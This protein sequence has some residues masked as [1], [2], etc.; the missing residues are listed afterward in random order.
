MRHLTRIFLLACTLA[1]AA[2]QLAA[3]PAADK[4]EEK[5]DT[6]A[7]VKKTPYEKLLGA[8]T[9]TV[10]GM[11]TVHIKKGKT[12]FEIPDSLYGREIVMGATVKSISDNGA[13]LVGSKNDLQLISFAREGGKVQV[14]ERNVE[15]VSDDQVLYKSTPG[16]ILASFDVKASAPDSSAV[17]DV[18]DYLLADNDA[19][20]PFVGYSTYQAYKLDKQFKKE[21]S[22]I[23]EAK[24]FEDNISVIVSRT[25]TFSATSG[26]GRKVIDKQNLTADMCY[27][28]LLLPTESYRPRVADPR[29]GYFFTQRKTM[30][31][32]GTSSKDIWL[33]NRW[34]VE[35]S[36]S[37]AWQ[38]GEKV[39]PKK[40]IVFYID[41]CFPDWWKPYIRKA[42]N[43][44]S[45]PFERIGFK[46]AV[47]ARDFPTQE[48]D[49]AFDP[50]NIKYS[51]IR[52]QP[53]GIQNAMGPSW[54]DPRTG[55]I[56][57]ASV[58][59]YHDVVRL[60]S[61]W[62]FVQTA[63]ADA[64]IRTMDIPQEKLGDALE[65]V[66]RHEVGHCLGLMH[67]MGASSSIPVESLRDPAFTAENGTTYSIM[68]YAR[69]NYVA[70]PGDKVKLTPPDFGK[71]D[72]WAIRWGYA[73]I[74]QAD[75]FA[76]EAAISKQ[77]ITD[78]LKAAPW[79]RYGKQQLYGQ[80][81]DPRNQ[82]EDLG[83]DVIKASRYGISNLKAVHGGF[84]DWLAEGD[85]E[86]EYRTSVYQAIVNQYMRYAGHILSNIGGMYRNEVVAADGVKRFENVP[87]DKQKACL[88]EILSML[89]NLDWIEDKSVQDKL[90]VL[91]SPAFTLRRSIYTS[92]LNTPYYC[93]MSDGVD[94]REF[95]FSECVDRIF[96]YTWKKPGRKLTKEQRMYQKEFILA[97]M[98]MG[99]IPIPEG[100][101]RALDG[102]A[103]GVEHDSGTLTYSPVSGFEWIP[104]AIFNRGDLTTADIYAVLSRV[105]D[106]LK[107][108]ARSA[109][110]LDKAHYQLLQSYISY[111]TTLK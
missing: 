57:N 79:Y 14:R 18:T 16:A 70:Q 87:A 91:G 96:D 83:D 84:M 56:I 48:E 55:E 100:A 7:A 99:S 34:R 22:Y 76:E 82:N 68:D 35:P 88:D 107:A 52:Y 90:P 71:Y 92:L 17:I 38:R 2:P 12:Y 30:A 69:F 67:N 103:E 4:K 58:Y 15:Y 32:V 8:G 78:S 77:M 49:P 47:V 44:W 72:Y 104:R 31:S 29:I 46:D 110:A 74:P 93:A 63:S 37:L 3:R 43:D 62:M 60:V 20:S 28:F 25:Y 5:K 19:M 6:T 86:Y 97:F 102:F 50:D 23:K 36:D 65:Y 98:R 61:Q 109:N 66:I 9:Q 13:G 51:C 108:R 105:N 26:A 1:A 42:V 40:Q 64:S 75:S 94:T 80:F 85:P 53:V 45:K 95:S 24:A 81:F 73:P 59:V 41:P 39:L 111:G 21:Y 33:A 101:D 54:T 89:D 27:S 10:N 106:V 11:I